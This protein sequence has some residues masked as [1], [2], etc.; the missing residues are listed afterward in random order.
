MR[1]FG[2]IASTS[3]ANRGRRFFGPGKGLRDTRPSYGG[4]REEILIGTRND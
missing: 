2:A 1:Q 4:G 3:D